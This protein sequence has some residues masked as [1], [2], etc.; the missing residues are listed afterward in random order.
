MPTIKVDRDRCK[1]C[2]LCNLYCPQRIIGM[3][4]SI[5]LKGYFFAEL[6]DPSRCIGCMLCAISCPDLAIS[7]YGNAVQYR[8]FD[9]FPSNFPSGE[10]AQ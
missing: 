3:S 5:N 7:V 10:R 4:K 6:K 9:Y 8:L 1:G 2:E